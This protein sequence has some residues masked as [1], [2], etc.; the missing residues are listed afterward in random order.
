MYPDNDAA[1]EFLALNKQRGDLFLLTLSA[2]KISLRL[3]GP[4]VVLNRPHSLSSDIAGLSTSIVKH[5]FESR[6][7]NS[8]FVGRASVGPLRHLRHNFFQPLRVRD[9]LRPRV[10]FV[11]HR[12]FLRRH[13]F[14]W[15]FDD[16]FGLS[17]P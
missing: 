9:V 15:L 13:V 2:Q 7:H 14:E 4:V 6:G 16:W 8:P 17:E 5:H 11:K 3:A 12:Q 10:L 1:I